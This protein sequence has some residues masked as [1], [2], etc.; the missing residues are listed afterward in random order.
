MPFTLEYDKLVES[1]KGIS[2]TTLRPRNLYRINSYKYADGT[3]K[4]LTGVTSSIVFVFGVTND[5]VFCVK[6]NDVRPE[7]FFEWLKTLLVKNL[8]N[9]DDVKLMEENIILADRPG[10]SIFNSYIK[11]KQIYNQNPCPYR[12]YNLKGIMNIEQIQLK[13]DALQKYLS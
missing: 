5:K 6:A 10:K 1:E 7:K 8:K 3:T 13:K 2:K 12:T 11:G 4:S 9:W